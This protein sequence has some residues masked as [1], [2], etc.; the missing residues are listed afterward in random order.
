MRIYRPNSQTEPQPYQPQVLENE[1]ISLEI[2]PTLEQLVAAH[3]YRLKSRQNELEL[4][5]FSK[6]F[7]SILAVVS[8][9]VLLLVLLIV[10]VFR[11]SQLPPE[12]PLY[13]D[14]SIET[15]QLIDKTFII[16]VPFAYLAWVGILLRLIS[17]VFRYDRRLSI[18]GS[19]IVI[20]INLLTIFAIAQ[21]SSLIT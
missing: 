14:A 12:L 1:Q 15:W 11:F 21:I 8:S 20:I 5:P 9:L 18:V 6:S 7:A 19:W 17:L 13:Y 3:K 4:Q 2:K 16:G 10:A